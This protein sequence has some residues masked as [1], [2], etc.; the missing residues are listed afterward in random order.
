MLCSPQNRSGNGAHVIINRL[1]RFRVRC[2]D[3]EFLKLVEKW[4]TV[5]GKW[6]EP[7]L[8]RKFLDA[9]KYYSNEHSK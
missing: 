9:I 6:D 7:E 1:Y 5:A 2:D 4:M 8:D 3:P